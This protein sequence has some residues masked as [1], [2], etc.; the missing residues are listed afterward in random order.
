MQVREVEMTP[1]LATKLLEGN[2]NNRRLNPRHVKSLA[3]AFADG[4]YL[5]DGTPVRLSK[6]GEVLDGQHRLEAI[7]SSGVTV[8]MLLIDDLDPA[9]QLVLDTGRPRSFVDFL[10]IHEVTNAHNTA[11]ATKLLWHYDRGH[12]QADGASWSYRAK[13]TNAQLWAFY[14]QHRDEV[15]EAI[16]QADAVVK[17]LRASPSAIAVGYIV[18]SRIDQDDAD[19][20]YAQL[21]HGIPQGPQVAALAK[22]FNTRRVRGDI[23]RLTQQEQL[24]LLF[25][26][27]N[28]Y[29]RGGQ[30][31]TVVWRRGG[32]SGEKFPTPE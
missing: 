6:T 20:F 12:M 23:R 2:T 19:H 22:S 3:A 25:K 21:A 18:L 32:K 29:R 8:P 26:T 14:Q 27:W 9:V 11:S 16:K 15:G 1:T 5:F 7:R 17:L 13:T 28:L 10:D 30:V 4:E 24:A 31:Q